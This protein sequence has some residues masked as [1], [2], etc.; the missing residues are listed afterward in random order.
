[1]VLRRYR[2]DV[3]RSHLSELTW[4]LHSWSGSI[5]GLNRTIC[6]EY[7][8]QLPYQNEQRPRR[9]QEGI[10]IKLFIE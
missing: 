6:A 1:M 9:E 3:Y 8:P 4:L 5:V 7:E 10:H 2:S